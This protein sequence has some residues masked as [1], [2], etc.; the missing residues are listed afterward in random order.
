MTIDTIVSLC[1]GN[2]SSSALEAVVNCKSMCLNG[3][4]SQW[5]STLPLGNQLKSTN[6]NQDQNQ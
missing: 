3:P 4:I 1:L 2:V 6:E 5:N